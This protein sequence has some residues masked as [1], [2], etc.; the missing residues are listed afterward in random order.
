[1]ES[2]IIAAIMAILTISTITVVTKRRGKK[3]MENCAS[4]IMDAEDIKPAKNIIHMPMNEILLQMIEESEQRIA[5]ENAGR[6]IFKRI[7]NK[8]KVG[9]TAKKLAKS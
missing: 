4:D 9:K 8:D 2:I 6:E 5:D 1:M 7:I 3:V